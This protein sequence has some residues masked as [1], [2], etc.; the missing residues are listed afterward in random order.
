MKQKVRKGEG[1]VGL[2][3]HPNGEKRALDKEKQVDS[4][5]VFVLKH[6][7]GDI[8]PLESRCIIAHFLGEQR[9]TPVHRK[10]YT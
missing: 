8:I 3:Q 9:N 2:V 10:T 7:N 6:F 1:G 4:W 5:S